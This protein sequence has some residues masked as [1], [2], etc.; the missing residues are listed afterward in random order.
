MTITLTKSAANQ[1]QQQIA[2]RG[3]GIALR[4]GIKRSGCSGFA[5]TFGFADEIK[6]GEK[7]F[8]SID[9]QVVVDATDLPFLNGSQIDFVQEGLSSF[10]K[11]NNPNIDNTCGCGES[12]NLKESVKV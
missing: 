4:I 1:I 8:T 5:Y 6:E 12:F 7:L 11:L 9:T 10:F 2:K 3:N